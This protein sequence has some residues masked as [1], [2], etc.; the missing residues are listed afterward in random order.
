V[1]Q[2]AGL[3]FTAGVYTVVTWMEEGTQIF[4]FAKSPVLISADAFEDNVELLWFRDL[5][6]GLKMTVEI[7]NSWEWLLAE[8][9]G[10]IYTFA[11]HGVEWD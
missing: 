9:A 10:E 1:S 5:M 6:V 7:A 11:F 3:G 4:P 2:S 8:G